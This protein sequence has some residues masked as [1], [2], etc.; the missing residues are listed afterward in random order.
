MRVVQFR[1]TSWSPHS[2]HLLF[3][4]TSYEVHIAVTLVAWVWSWRLRNTHGLGLRAGLFFGGGGVLT[5][6]YMRN[7]PLLPLKVCMEMLVASRVV[8]RFGAL[9]FRRGP[10]P[11]SSRQICLISRRASTSQPTA[12]GLYSWPS[13]NTKALLR[14]L[15]VHLQFR[16]VEAGAR[17]GLPIASIP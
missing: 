8:S 12:S 6:K 13:S 16:L 3:G 4:K 2:I 10:R 5:E 15:G 11:T 14:P 9:W 17:R 7:R 1:A